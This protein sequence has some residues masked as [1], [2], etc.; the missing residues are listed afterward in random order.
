LNDLQQ[1][2]LERE[3]KDLQKKISKDIQNQGLFE[4]ENIK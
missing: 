3:I 1:E 2:S 4:N